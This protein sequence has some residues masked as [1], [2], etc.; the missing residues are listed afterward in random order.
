MCQSLFLT[1]GI[2]P[3]VR[4]RP[5]S[6]WDYNLV[7]GGGE[8]PW[9]W[10]Q[11]HMQRRKNKAREVGREGM[12]A[13][14]GIM[15]REGLLIK[16]IYWECGFFKSRVSQLIEQ[17][18]QRSWDRRGLAGE[19]KVEEVS[20]AAAESGRG[21][22]WEVRS[23]S[24]SRVCITQGPTNHGENS[25]YSS[26]WAESPFEGSVQILSRTWYT[27]SSRRPTLTVVWRINR[28]QCAETKRSAVAV[29][30]VQ[31]RTG[32]SST[33]TDIFDVWLILSLQPC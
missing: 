15:V 10:C 2:K 30:I 6:L 4:W 14:L 3:W 11:G 13:I 17:S 29:A 19:R 12:G 32:E 21:E 22:C 7:K 23:E 24:L 28:C 18:V 20:V 1:P 16:Q 9:I 5:Q 25:G 26:E 33:R 8:W 31:A 27:L